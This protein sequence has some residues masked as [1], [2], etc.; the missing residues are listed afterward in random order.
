MLVKVFIRIVNDNY[1]DKK[2]AKYLEDNEVN[3][4]LHKHAAVSTVAES[5][6]NEEIGKI[7]GL[8]CK[9]LFL[10]DDKGGFYLIGL[11]AH[12]RL[13]IKKLERHL[14]VKKLKFGLPDELDRFGLV[15]G[16]VSIFGAI[17]S[18]DIVLI[19]DKEVWDAEIVGFHP[20]VN[21]ETLEIGHG[22]LEKYYNSLAN[23]KEIVEL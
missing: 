11:S 15:P 20:N 6:G 14:K 4:V 7:P 10:K 13:D 23:K 2:L 19:L 5:S 9:T 3:Y 12:K 16:S 1:M 21:T 17:Y 18:S 22:G 8:H